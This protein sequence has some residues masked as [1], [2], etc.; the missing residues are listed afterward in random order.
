MTTNISS[1]IQRYW[2]QYQHASQP[3]GSITETET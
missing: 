1:H 3:H 2:F